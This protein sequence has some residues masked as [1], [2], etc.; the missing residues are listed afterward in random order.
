MYLRTYVNVHMYGNPYMHDVFNMYLCII[1]LWFCT[2]TSVKHVQFTQRTYVRITPVLM[3]V[4]SI[5]CIRHYTYVYINVHVQ[6]G[7]FIT[8]LLVPHFP[9]HYN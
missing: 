7:L 3:Y 9:F 4:C 6:P 1:L 2:S 8:S 5:V